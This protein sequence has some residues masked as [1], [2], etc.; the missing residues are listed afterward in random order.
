MP[1]K[2]VEPI[3]IPVRITFPDNTELW[4]TIDPTTGHHGGHIFSD[5]PSCTICCPKTTS[6]ISLTILHGEYHKHSFNLF[7]GSCGTHLNLKVKKSWE[8]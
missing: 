6:W 1:S 8:M 3:T 5:L 2:P 7:S 4:T